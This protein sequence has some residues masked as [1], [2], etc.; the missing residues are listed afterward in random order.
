MNKLIDEQINV[1]GNHEPHYV[2]IASSDTDGVSK[3]T[4]Y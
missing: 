4:V 1:D 2:L 3:P